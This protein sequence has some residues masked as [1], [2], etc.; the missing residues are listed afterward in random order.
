MPE[1]YRKWL[2]TLN[3]EQA[4]ELLNWLD[5]TPGVEDFIQTARVLER[6]HPNL[7]GPDKPYNSGSYPLEIVSS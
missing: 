2:E 5:G 7:F 1:F 4:E 6:V 3:Q